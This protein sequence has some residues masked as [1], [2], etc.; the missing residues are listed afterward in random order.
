VLATLR[1]LGS[2]SHAAC[3]IIPGTSQTFRATQTAIDRP[4]ASPGDVVELALDPTCYPI[5]RTYSLDPAEQTVTV[6]FT[7]RRAVRATSPYWRPAA[8]A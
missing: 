4:F 1:L 7:L 8:Q 5:E 2:E 6:V 3:N